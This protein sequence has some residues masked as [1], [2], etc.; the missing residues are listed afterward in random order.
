[1]NPLAKRQ[2]Q[3]AEAAIKLK[4]GHFQ[5]APCWPDPSGDQMKNIGDNISA[6][7]QYFCLQLGLDNQIYEQAEA[8]KYKEDGS[9]TFLKKN[10]WDSLEQLQQAKE[11]AIEA[12][13]H[14]DSWNQEVDRSENSI[15]VSLDLSKDIS[16]MSVEEIESKRTELGDVLRADQQAYTLHEFAQEAKEEAD[17]KMKIALAAELSLAEVMIAVVKN[18]HDVTTSFDNAVQQSI[19]SNSPLDDGSAGPSNQGLELKEVDMTKMS[20][21]DEPPIVLISSRPINVAFQAALKAGAAYQDALEATQKYKTVKLRWGRCVANLCTTYQENSDPHQYIDYVRA[22]DA[23]L[24]G[25]FWVGKR[26]QATKGWGAA[27]PGASCAL[28]C[29]N[30]LRQYRPV[31]LKSDGSYKA[32]YEWKT[33]IAERWKGNS[34]LSSVDITTPEALSEYKKKWLERYQ[35]R[36]ANS[37]VATSVPSA[38]DDKEDD[39]EFSLD[40]FFTNAEEDPK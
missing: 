6:V 12:Y 28:L 22:T 18:H 25:L 4:G 14:R 11:K 31:S 5:A 3:L 32:N 30:K 33:K 7:I 17:I 24:V 20:L 16:S 8:K 1:M 37:S 38:F 35:S 36:I 13:D 10:L 39:K 21:S 2:S 19:V 40:I 15:G 29:E 27:L 23:D 9:I 34:H 26:A